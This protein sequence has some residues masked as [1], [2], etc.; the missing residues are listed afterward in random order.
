M[1][2][3]QNDSIIRTWIQTTDYNALQRLSDNLDQLIQQT[4]SHRQQKLSFIQKLKDENRYHGQAKTILNNQVTNMNEILTKYTRYQTFINEENVPLASTITLQC[5]ITAQ[6]DSVDH[7]QTLDGYYYQKW[8]KIATTS[9]DDLS[10]QSIAL[11]TVAVEKLISQIINAIKKKLPQVK[12]EFQKPES[13]FQKNL[14]KTLKQSRETFA[15]FCGVDEK[16]I[17][18]LNQQDLQLE[19]KMSFNDKLK[20]M[21]NA[22]NSVNQNL[23]FKHD[24]NFTGIDKAIFE[25]VNATIIQALERGDTKSY[26][27]YIQ[28][29]QIHQEYECIYNALRT[30]KSIHLVKRIAS[31]GQIYNGVINLSSQE[32]CFSDPNECLKQVHIPFF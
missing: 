8:I 17:D 25:N 20:R 14:K 3:E 16:N 5:A 7:L 11:E 24:L 26:K 10:V 12:Y 31:N 30:G 6:V 28:L 23:Q 21:I 22:F 19:W 1:C 18:V 27:Y 29:N 9:I 13:L 32:D 2:F 4:K 15:D